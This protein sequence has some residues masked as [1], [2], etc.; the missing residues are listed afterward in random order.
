MDTADST[1]ENAVSSIKGAR[2]KKSIAQ[3][4]KVKIIH[5]DDATPETALQEALEALDNTHLP[6]EATRRGRSR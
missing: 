1:R 4:P 6:D 2:I 3:S 5:K